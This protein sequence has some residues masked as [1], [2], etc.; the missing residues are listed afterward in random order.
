MRLADCRP[1]P[2]SLVR[3]SRSGSMC[4]QRA[5]NE[6]GDFFGPLDCKVRWLTRRARS[7]CSSRS[8]AKMLEVHAIVERALDGDDIDVELVEVGQRAL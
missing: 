5:A 6:V 8:S 4:F 2:Q 7:S 3:I 1:K